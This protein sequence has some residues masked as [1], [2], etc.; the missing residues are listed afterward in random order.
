[1]ALAGLK[2]LSSYG[3]AGVVFAATYAGV[4]ACSSTETTFVD[5]PDDESPT[6]AGFDTKPSAESG[7]GVLTFMPETSF[8]GF[9]G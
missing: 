2:R 6:D 5:E 3:L 9:D 1:M 8:S 7:L 4:F